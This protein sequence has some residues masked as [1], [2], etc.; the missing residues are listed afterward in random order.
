MKSNFNMI[1]RDKVMVLVDTSEAD[2]T[3][4]NFAALVAK[5]SDT[6]EIHVFNSIPAL[7]IPEN[8]L[9]EFPDLRDR[10]FEDRKNKIQEAIDN[11]VDA[12]IKPIIQIHIEEGA[13][14]KGVLNFIEKHSIDLLMMGRHRDFRGHGVL[15]SRLARRA[16][17]S[18]FI[19]PQD[20]APNPNYLLVPC[21][22][23]KYSKLAMQTG[24]ELAKRYG[25]ERLVCQNVYSVPSSWHYS[26]KTYEE[27]AEIMKENAQKSFKK[28]MK[29]IDQKGIKI[30]DVYS[31]DKDDNPV[32][33]ITDY[34]EE[35]Q[36]GCVI[37]GAKGRTATTALFIGSKAEK[38]VQENTGTPM[39]LVRPKGKNEGIIDLIKQI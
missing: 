11:N 3:L 16:T 17:C 14:S 32:N 5:A 15:S 29:G 18:L 33:D 38:F 1:S 19:V 35:T 34:M 30:E 31:I 39:L 13:P 2:N 28:F 20:A 9:K 21:D 12:E 25:S 24:I 4:L 27:F 22:F 10:A 7:N 36:P 6:K 23:S 8:I 26:G 37:I